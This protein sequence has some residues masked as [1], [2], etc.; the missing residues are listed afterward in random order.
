MEKTTAASRRMP[1]LCPEGRPRDVRL[2]ARFASK[3][4]NS[5]NAPRKRVTGECESGDR[6]A[7]PHPPVRASECQ[8]TTVTRSSISPTVSVTLSLK[9]RRAF[10]LTRPVVASNTT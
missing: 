2:T 1:S 10:A 8:G 5:S 7:A 4:S 6:A 9:R 3:G